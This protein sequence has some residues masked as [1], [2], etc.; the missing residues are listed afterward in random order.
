MG[1]VSMSKGR[2]LLLSSSGRGDGVSSIQ[3]A[4]NRYE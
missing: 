3:G 1:F 2:L 4:G